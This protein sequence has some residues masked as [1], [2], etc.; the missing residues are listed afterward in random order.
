LSAELNPSHVTFMDPEP[1]KAYCREVSFPAGAALRTKGLLSVDMYL[2]TDGEVEVSIDRKLAPSLRLAARRGAPIGEIGFLTG[3]P[4]TATVTAR[5]DARALYIDNSAWRE[6]E[7]RQPDLAVE[8]YRH[9]AEVADGRQSHNLLFRADEEPA[10]EANTAEIVLCQTPELLHSAQQIRYQIYCGEL[11][12]TSPFADAE[13]GIIADELDEAGH[14]LLALDNGVPVATL[15]MNMR[16][17]GSLGLLEDLYGMAQSPHHPEGTAICTKFIVKKSHRLGQFC[18]RLMSTAVEM[19]Q[20]YD[21]KHCYIDCI[22]ELRPFYATLGFAQSGPAFLHR[23]NGRSYPLMLD[24]DRYA[25]RI[26]RL[27]GFVLR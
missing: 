20:R 27:S 15:R 3:V 13:K 10:R 7:R 12:R 26:A 6:L 11:G 24:I 14:V 25:R 9:L 21:I 23:E 4:A 2:L 1:L 16:R 5:T 22:P 18:F 19:A 8:L 17:D